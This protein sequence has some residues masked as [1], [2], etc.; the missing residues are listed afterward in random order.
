VLLLHAF[1]EYIVEQSRPPDFFPKLMKQMLKALEYLDRHGVIHRDV[2]PDNILRDEAG[3]YYLADFGLSKFQNMT[4][5]IIGT[6]GYVAPEIFDPTIPQSPKMDIWSM[7]VLALDVLGL[8]PP[9][10]PWAGVEVR[11]GDSDWVDSI[12]EHARNFVPQILPML[13]VD[14]RKRFSAKECLEK[15]FNDE[16]RVRNMRIVRSTGGDKGVARGWTW[17]QVAQDQ[18]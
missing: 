11:F 1:T 15:I 5:S 8:L 18:L 2:K 7:G 6:P 14:P 10:P 13:Q 9:D 17:Q 16:V 3:N 12:V 4:H